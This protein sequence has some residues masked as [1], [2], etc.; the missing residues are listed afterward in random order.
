MVSEPHMSLFS[1]LVL[2]QVKAFRLQIACVN[3]SLGE[4]ETVSLTIV[5]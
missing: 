3:I 2:L 4:T 1:F 5:W